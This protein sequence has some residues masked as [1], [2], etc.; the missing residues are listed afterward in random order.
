V[1]LQETLALLG[2]VIDD[3]DNLGDPALAARAYV[4]IGIAR[5]LSGEQYRTSPELASVLE[6][7]TALAKESGSPALI[8]MAVASTGHARYA[9]ADFDE[10]IVLMEQAV[11]ALVDAG[12]FYGA[13]MTAG[14]LGTAYGH[15][16]DFDKAAHWTD[17]AYEL[18]VESGDPNASLDADLA[19]SIV[20]GI[21]GD[22][23]AAIAYATKA[24]TVADRVDNR[25]CAMVAHSVIGEQYLRD[26][27]PAKAAIA[28]EASA[29][30]AA[31]CQFMP[32]KI[33]QTELLLQT[34][35]ARSGVGRVEFERYER[36]L[37]L[38]RQFGDRLAE[39]QL[40]E[41]RARDRI[42]GGQGE[43]SADDVRAAAAIF[44]SLGA[45]AHLERVRE[46]QAEINLSD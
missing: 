20:E 30:L 8:A 44:E 28:F 3:A 25:A 29:D 5:A 34:A 42:A 16:G 39:A 15:V 45:A 31:F 36:A 26:G 32:V 24:A 22:S 27:D 9:S 43:T 13:S 37:E 1:P 40:Y 38:A 35:R 19:R 23:A 7:G 2:D 41:Q 11:P 4:D 12:Q 18:G 14:Q 17:R 10:A 46:L 6:R 33:E 21:R